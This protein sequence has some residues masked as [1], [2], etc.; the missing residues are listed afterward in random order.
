MDQNYNDELSEFLLSTAPT[1][2]PQTA[3]EQILTKYNEKVEDGLKMTLVKSVLFNK[4]K[5]QTWQ[6]C[7]QEENGVIF[8]GFLRIHMNFSR[9]INVIAGEK[10]P[11][12]YDVVNESPWVERTGSDTFSSMG[13][14]TITSFYLPRNTEKILHVTRY[15]LLINLRSPRFQIANKWLTILII[16]QLS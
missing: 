1:E 6:I 11:T 9:P 12:L 16:T 15:C 3:L 10:P 5:H 4:F 13:R 2:L 7:F 14:K 8:R